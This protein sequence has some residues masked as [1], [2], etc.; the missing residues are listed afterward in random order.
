MRQMATVVEQA[1]SGNLTPVNGRRDL[2]VPWQSNQLEWSKE[3]GDVFT[4][5][6]MTGLCW[7]NPKP[8]RGKFSA[9]MLTGKS[10][11]PPG[12]ERINVR[13]A[14]D[15]GLAALRRHLR[16]ARPALVSDWEYQ[17]LSKRKAP[18]LKATA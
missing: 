14:N 5:E 11:R 3:V 10:I 4:A 17:P 1:I 12:A 9:S 15:N 18:R 7:S 16:I 8:S 2:L 13:A 6:L